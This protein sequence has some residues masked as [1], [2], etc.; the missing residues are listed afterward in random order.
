MVLEAETKDS[1]EARIQLLK[2]ADRKIRTALN[3]IYADIETTSKSFARRTSTP[4]LQLGN[5]TNSYMGYLTSDMQ[6]ATKYVGARMQLLEYMGQTK[7]AKSV[8]QQYQH[9]MYDL[10]TKPVTRKGLST[11]ALM[12]DYFPYDKSNMNC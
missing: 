4:F 7:T 5:Q 12:Y 8:L 10:L 9:V 11:A 6:I 2:E 1:E 3:A